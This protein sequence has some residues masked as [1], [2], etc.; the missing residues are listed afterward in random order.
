M[1][2]VI[3]AN[4]QKIIVFAENSKF[5]RWI[6]H[7]NVKY[8]WVHKTIADDKINLKYFFINEM[9]ANELIKFLIIRKF[10]IFLNM[11]NMC[12]IIMR[13]LPVSASNIKNVKRI[14]LDL[15]NTFLFDYLKYVKI[16]RWKI[17]ENVS[18][19]W[20]LIASHCF[21]FIIASSNIFIANV[22]IKIM[23]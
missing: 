16:N 21:A 15:S 3:W 11:I 22:I 20:Y 7:I 5:H 18:D 6:K 10:A 1:S 23:H 13:L 4:N 9:I 2:I 14:K 8:H 12:K 17:T 19:V